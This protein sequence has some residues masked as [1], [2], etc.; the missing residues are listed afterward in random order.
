MCYHRTGED[1]GIHSARF[2]L[3]GANFA[4]T[5]SPTEFLSF[6]E[7]LSEETLSFCTCQ[8]ALYHQ[9]APAILYVIIYFVCNGMLVHAEVRGQAQVSPTL[10]SEAWCLIGLEI[11]LLARLARQ[12]TSGIDLPLP[13]QCWGYKHAPPQLPFFMSSR[14]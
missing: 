13:P 14:D 1:S 11:I 4:A 12:R 9:A 8:Q 5:T 2:L 7:V 3:V 10:F 6:S